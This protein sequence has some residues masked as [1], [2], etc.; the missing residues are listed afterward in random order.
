MCA[1][2]IVI[3]SRLS[4]VSCDGGGFSLEYPSIAMHGVSR[5]TASFPH[6]CL[7]LMLDS[8]IDGEAIL[9]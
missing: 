1:M 3:F 5:D 4:W 6:E 8:N 9:M 2:W 7:Y